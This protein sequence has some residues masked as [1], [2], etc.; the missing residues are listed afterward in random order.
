MATNAYDLP[1]GNFDLPIY[2]LFRSNLF[3]K[4]SSLVILSTTSNSLN[5]Q[6]FQVQTF[7]IMKFKGRNAVMQYLS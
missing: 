3:H 1:M 5:S 7:L 6:I 4:M 2:T